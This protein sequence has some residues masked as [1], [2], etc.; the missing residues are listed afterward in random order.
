LDAALR[1][2]PN[3]SAA[4]RLIDQIHG[5]PRE[6]MRG[7]ARAYTVRQGETLSA[8]AERFQGDALLFYALARFND[9]DAPNQVGEGQVLMIP[10][11]PGL[12]NASVETQ[13]PPPP[14]ASA[15]VPGSAPRRPNAARADQL[16]LQA[17]RQMNSGQIDGAVA[18][19]RQAH[20]LDA[21]NPAVQRDLDRAVRLQA[22]L[23][24][25]GGAPN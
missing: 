20:A 22:S 17:L 1:A 2:D 25:N 6:L 5:E 8:L 10:R 15:S 11:R 23:R 7:E 3:M 21:G 14:A 19:L 24:A 13:P 16:R 12:R 18:L 9:L 4:R